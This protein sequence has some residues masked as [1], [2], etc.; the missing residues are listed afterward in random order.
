MTEDQA[1]ILQ[2][3]VANTL[4]QVGDFVDSAALWETLGITLGFI[5]IVSLIAFLVTKIFSAFNFRAR[6]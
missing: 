2:A 5:L 3:S 1:T 6:Y 4:G